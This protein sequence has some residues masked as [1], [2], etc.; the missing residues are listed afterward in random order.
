MPPIPGHLPVEQRPRRPGP[1]RRALYLI[2][3]FHQH[4]VA[5]Q[6]MDADQREQPVQPRPSV[7]RQ[8]YLGLFL[9][10]CGY[11]ASG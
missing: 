7:P 5:Y 11:A 9:L 6:G 8:K 3:F 1:P 2:V 10:A 4:H